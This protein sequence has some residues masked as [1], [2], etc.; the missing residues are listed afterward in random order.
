MATRRLH[1]IRAK[2]YV[3]RRLWL[4]TGEFIPLHGM[5]SPRSQGSRA[6]IFVGEL[7]TKPSGAWTSARDN[8]PLASD[9]KRPSLGP[10][11]RPIPSVLAWRLVAAWD[12]YHYGT[13][14]QLEHGINYAQAYL[15]RSNITPQRPRSLAI[16][17][18]APSG[19]HRGS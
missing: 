14:G 13:L 1:G 19:G 15:D 3:Q 6:P 9:K 16:P 18:R 10:S 8:T 4:I 11:Q 5:R 12:H 17:Q 7:C 2:R